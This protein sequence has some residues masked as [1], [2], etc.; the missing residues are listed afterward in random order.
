M[1]H[2]TSSTRNDYERKI[3]YDWPYHKI[4]FF[5]NIKKV[6]SEKEE[7][8]HSTTLVDYFLYP[9]CP[10]NGRREKINLHFN[11]HT[12]LWYLSRFMKALKATQKCENKNFS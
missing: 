5:K 6:I 1:P 2:R 4:T 12:S 9:S 11:F 3:N 10:D 8:T 7:K